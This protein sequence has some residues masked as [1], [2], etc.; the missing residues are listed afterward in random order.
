MA[1]DPDGPVAADALVIGAGPGGGSAAL[2]LARAGVDVIVVEEHSEPG[3]PV[4]CGECLSDIALEH[5]GMEIPDSVVSRRVDG[6]RVIFPDGSARHLSEGGVV[7]EKHLWE[8]WIIEQA[9]Q[10]G[11][12]LHSDTRVTGL[13]RVGELWE[14]EVRGDHPGYQVQVVVDASGVAAVAPKLLGW[15]EPVEVVAGLQVELLDVPS[16]GYLDFYLWP[17]LAPE[18][19]LWMIPKADGRANVGLVTTARK[20]AMDRVRE[21]IAATGLR[22]KPVTGPPWWEAG[23]EVR[24]FGGTIPVSGPRRRTAADGLLLV[25][26]AAGFTSPLFEGGSHLALASGRMAGEVLAEGLAAKDVSA[27]RLAAYE[28]GW[29]AEFPPYDRILAGKAALYDLAPHELA[30]L[31]RCLP[32]EMA[33]MGALGKAAVGMRLLT[34][35]P[36]LLARRAI[37]VLQ[38]FGLSR[39]ARYGW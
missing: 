6:I 34:R 8:Q 17:H 1:G 23:K 12:Q 13:T 39:A 2:S 37:P 24:A 26:D 29:K 38:A 19:Y 14:V 3:V 15:D 25:G 10:A 18:G 11:A 20:G 33:T 7:L 5:L 36:A 27:G 30:A 32:H 31:G 16:D 21:F 22:Q 35:E 4:H 28:T 9:V